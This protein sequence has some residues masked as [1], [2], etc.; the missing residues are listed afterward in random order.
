MSLKTYNYTKVVAPDTLEFQIRN[1]SIKTSLESIVSTSTT[2]DITFKATLDTNDESILTAI[3]NVHVAIP[4]LYQGTPKDADGA[5]IIRPKAAKAGWAYQMHSTSFYTSQLDSVFSYKINPVTRLRTPTGFITS[6]FY[7]ADNVELTEPPQMNRCVWS[8]YDWCPNFEMELIGGK[9]TQRVSP[10]T[11]VYLW[12]HLAPGI[13]N[14]PFLE[15][16]VN[17]ELVNSAS[18]IVADG[19]VSKYMHPTLPMPGLNKFR[20]T[21]LHPPGFVHEMQC[22]Y[23]FFKSIT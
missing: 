12:M 20:T 18:M 5:Q 16:G 21:I 23:E 2:V 7:D 19:R 6:K 17:L 15:G 11:D 4:L 9:L 3:I 1:S 8:V 14:Y 10:D 22:I 13:L